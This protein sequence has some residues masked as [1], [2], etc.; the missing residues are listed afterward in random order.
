MTDRTHRIHELAALAGVTV[1]TLRHYD[2][3]GLLQPHRTAAR[4]RLY[5]EAERSRL[6]QIL[7]LRSL[8]LPLRRIRDLLAPGAP[9]LHQALHQQR[10]VLQAQRR[11]L[12]RTI[13][14][15]EA[16]EG[17]LEASPE[18]AS[19]VLRTL[20]EVTGMA[21]SIDEMRKYYSD[22]VW[23]AWRQHYEDWPSPAW[24]ALYRDIIQALDAPHPPDPTS[25][26]AQ[27]LGERWLIL[28]RGETRVGAIRAGMRQA[29]ADR[30]HWPDALRAQLTEHRVDRALTFINIVLWERWDAERLARERAGDLAPARVS[31]ARR[32]LYRDCAAALATGQGAAAAP[33]LVARWRAILDEECGG[34]EEI[35]RE[36]VRA[37]R[38]RRE[39]APGLLRYTASCYEMDATTWLQVADFIESALDRPAG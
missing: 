4:Y 5:T 22:D 11:L 10:Q 25:A 39:W 26:E 7:A 24:R 15:L 30:E 34:D 1:K 28:D 35:A 3:V 32:D 31:D 19:D 18:R 14:A 16:A 29:W 6:Q 2:R 38:G 36:Q 20:L 17:M 33:E 21:D 37:W 13:R 12:E 8:G 27:A 23:D 9:P